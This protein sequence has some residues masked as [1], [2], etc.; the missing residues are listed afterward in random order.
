M[1][2]EHTVFD[3][4]V[5]LTELKQSNRLTSLAISATASGGVAA[6]ALVFGVVLVTV[7][8]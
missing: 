4:D 8:A 5:V 1:R 3:H 7:G 2:A 6:L